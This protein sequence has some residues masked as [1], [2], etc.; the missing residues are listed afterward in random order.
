MRNSGAAVRSVVKEQ[1]V[2][3]QIVKEQIV[4]EQIVIN[5][6]A[7]KSSS[8]TITAGRGSATARH[9]LWAHEVRSQIQ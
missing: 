3:E 7:S 9:C 8:C 1:I 4:K 5:D 6:V 2:K